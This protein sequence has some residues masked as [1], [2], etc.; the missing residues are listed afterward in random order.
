ML[1]LIQPQ[2]VSGITNEMM[3]G[4]SPNE[5][6]EL[7]ENANWQILANSIGF[8]RQQNINQRDSAIKMGKDF[9]N[10]L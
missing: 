1:S 4:I 8:I 7:P 10:E 3:N 9:I 5:N 6:G 2:I